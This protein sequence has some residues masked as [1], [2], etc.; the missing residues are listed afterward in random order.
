VTPAQESVVA[1][2][3][4][5]PATGTA[6]V[7]GREVGFTADIGQGSET[8]PQPVRGIV[9]NEAARSADQAAAQARKNDRAGAKS[10]GGKSAITQAKPKTTGAA[11]GRGLVAA[12]GEGIVDFDDD[13]NPREW[14]ALAGTVGGF[15]PN[16]A[17]VS[18]NLSAAIREGETL[19]DMSARLYGTRGHAARLLAMNPDLLADNPLAAGDLL[20][21]M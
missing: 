11:K 18:G 17:A 2:I 3:T 10:G 21:V 4:P 5:N 14:G 12:A 9:Q 13:V 16:P 1:A 15:D 20:R 6:L 7:A 19:G 8:K